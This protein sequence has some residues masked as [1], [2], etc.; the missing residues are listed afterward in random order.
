MC[1]WDILEVQFI[2]GLKRFCL[3]CVH[4]GEKQP[5]G[6]FESRN[7]IVDVRIVGD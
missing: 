4:R 1:V 7:I 5:G 2:D 3:F 6:C